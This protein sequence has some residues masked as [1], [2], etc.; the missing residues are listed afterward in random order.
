MS[1]KYIILI[2]IIIIGCGRPTE[3][4][5][6]LDNYLDKYINFELKI[7]STSGKLNN[8]FYI[9]YATE[10]LIFNEVTQNKIPLETLSFTETSSFKFQIDNMSVIDICYSPTEYIFDNAESNSSTI[11]IIYNHDHNSVQVMGDS[12]KDVQISIGE[13]IIDKDSYWLRN[14]KYYSTYC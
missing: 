1:K 10:Q 14:D 11:F 4:S 3:T 9:S 8:N 2:F 13:N 7:E 6:N 12:V 5:E